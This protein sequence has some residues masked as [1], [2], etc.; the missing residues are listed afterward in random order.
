MLYTRSRLI[1]I[2]KTL[3]Q[4]LM[5]PLIIFQEKHLMYN[6]AFYKKVIVSSQINDLLIVVPYIYF[7]GKKGLSHLNAKQ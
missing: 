2:M 7:R 6:N 3:K 1:C 4:N 5:V